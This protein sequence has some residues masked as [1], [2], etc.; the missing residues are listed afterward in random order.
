MATDESGQV[1]VT[2]P[3]VLRTRRPT[4]LGVVA[5]AGRDKTIKVTF[6]YLRRRAVLHAHDEQNEAREGDMVEV[7]ECRPISK[8]KHW[9]LLRVVQR[10]LAKA[11]EAVF[12]PQPVVGG[13]A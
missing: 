6:T 3:R 12:E 1:I 7:C 9:R 8:T 11:P 2:P 4:R 13:E 10:G 5:S